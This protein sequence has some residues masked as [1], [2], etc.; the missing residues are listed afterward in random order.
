ML[1]RSAVHPNLSGTGSRRC[2][3]SEHLQQLQRK[4]PRHNL[5]QLQRK[6]PRHSLQQLP[7]GA[8]AQFAGRGQQMCR[9]R[10]Q[11]APP[12]GD[13]AA[14]GRSLRARSPACRTQPGVPGFQALGTQPGVPDFQ[15]LG[16]RP[17]LR[18]LAGGSSGPS[19]LQ[20]AAAG[21]C[22]ARSPAAGCSA[23]RAQEP[24]QTR[25]KASEQA[26]ARSSATRALCRRARTKLGM[27]LRQQGGRVR[28]AGAREGGSEMRSHARIRDTIACEDPR[29]DRMRGSEMR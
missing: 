29:C 13:P 8:T 10:A 23:S 9:G 3:S 18:G 6:V 2:L 27:P 16:T 7:Q 15:A 21:A 4:V 1:L 24:A 14:P 5:Q 25:G 22:T 20:M 28:E 19:A 11:N 17:G 12:A 26:P